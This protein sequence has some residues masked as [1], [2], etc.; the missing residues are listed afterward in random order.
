MVKGKG[1]PEGITEFIVSTKR[2]APGL[3]LAQIADKVEARFDRKVD[4]STV[5]KVLR[6]ANLGRGQAQAPLGVEPAGADSAQDLVLQN[7]RLEHVSK[8]KRAA[9][10]LS[11]QLTL[12]HP[13]GLGS[14]PEPE[15]W[16]RQRTVGRLTWW[17]AGSRDYESLWIPETGG[18]GVFRLHARNADYFP[19]LQG[20]IPG[21]TLGEDLGKWEKG[22]ADLL[23][24]CR[25]LMGQIVDVCE[26][27][28]GVK[29][30]TPRGPS[31][32]GLFWGFPKQV[33]MDALNKAAGFR[34]PH[35]DSSYAQGSGLLILQRGGEKLAAAK[36]QGQLQSL[37]GAHR[38][39][40]AS[41][42]WSASAQAMVAR[43]QDL[44]KRA[45]AIQTVLRRETE[46]GLFDGG[47]CDYCPEPRLHGVS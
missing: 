32:R 39:L 27:E 45:R 40:L 5:G 46:R 28:A 47:R 9:E 10:E 18:P 17:T 8:L 4:K 15:S 35:P 19:R 43:Y 23:W 11:K 25:Q 44:E 34:P 42:D 6:R 36:N 22:A 41:G 38:R 21:P 2:N 29:L 13:N 16:A 37:E 20:H 7:A 24:G 3:T 33:Y 14:W 26:R 31:I 1:L 12:P 30:C